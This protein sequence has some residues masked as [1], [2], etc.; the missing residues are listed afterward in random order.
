MNSFLN[1]KANLK[2]INIR[3]QYNVIPV[4]YV[5]IKSQT[6]KKIESNDLIHKIDIDYRCYLSD[7][8]TGEP[9]QN[10]REISSVFQEKNNKGQGIRIA[11]VDS[12]IEPNLKKLKKSI[13]S[14]VD[15]TTEPWDDLAGHGTL[16]AGVIA[17]IVPKSEFVDVKI[18]SRSGLVYASHVL[19]G[20]DQ[21]FSIQI[22]ILMLGV[23]SPVPTDGSDVLTTML[24]KYVDKGVLVVVP[25]GNFGPEANT[26]GFAS[27]ISNSFCIGSLNPNEEVSYFSSRTTEKPDFYVIGE[28]ITS[29]SS[30][31][32]ILG[33]LHP[34]NSEKRIISGT[35]VAAA[36]FTGL[37]ATIK[38][39]C[40]DYGY[41]DLYDFFRQL[42]SE[43]GFLSKRKINESFGLSKMKRSPFKRALLISSLVTLTLALFGI[44]SIFLFR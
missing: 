17:D 40:P 27:Q 20:L 26:V 41:K 12:G 5:K 29:T 2:K 37:L 30:F 11:L 18:S 23:S 16:M 44:G 3:Y 22:D 31:H 7:N 24:E 8:S 38:Q 36:K 28:N 6:L 1:K 39:E 43:S 19:K 13:V 42:S 14:K 25:A 4:L 15:I 21:L 9:I 34:T 33:R 32:G 35:S 10:N